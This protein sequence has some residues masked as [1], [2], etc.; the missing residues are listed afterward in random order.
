MRRKFRI[1]CAILRISASI[2]QL[3]LVNIDNVE[4]S[5]TCEGFKLVLEAGNLPSPDNGLPSVKDFEAELGKELE[6]FRMVFQERLSIAVTSSTL[7]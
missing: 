3:Q 4:F 2:E 7:P 5:H 1:L 6:H